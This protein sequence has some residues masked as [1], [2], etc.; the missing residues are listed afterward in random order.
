[1]DPGLWRANANTVELRLSSK[2]M[3]ERGE[4]ITEEAKL[5]RTLET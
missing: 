1:M 5:A 4:G 3:R 2:G